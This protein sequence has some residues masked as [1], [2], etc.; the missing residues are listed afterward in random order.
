MREREMHI[1]VYIYNIWRERL[2]ERK[3]ERDGRVKYREKKVSMKAFPTE[4]SKN[5]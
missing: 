5:S 2:S 1:Y 4:N 3:I